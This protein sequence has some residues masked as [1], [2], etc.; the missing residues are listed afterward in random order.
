MTRHERSGEMY[1][2]LQ[3]LNADSAGVCDVRQNHRVF[4]IP[5]YRPA[6]IIMALHCLRATVKLVLSSTWRLMLLVAQHKPQSTLDRGLRNSRGVINITHGICTA[7]TEPLLHR[8]LVCTQRHTT[9][10]KEA[11]VNNPLRG[12]GESHFS[13]LTP[14]ESNLAQAMVSTH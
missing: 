4:S 10:V 8:A 12:D 6:V 14:Q 13:D 9:A 11:H 2:H 5:K 7:N 3:M 1:S